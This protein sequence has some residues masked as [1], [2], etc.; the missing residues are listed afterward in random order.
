MLGIKKT[1]AAGQKYLCVAGIQIPYQTE[2]NGFSRRFRIG[3]IEMPY[4]I[5]PVFGI[6][7]PWEGGIK[8]IQYSPPQRQKSAHYHSRELWEDPQKLQQRLEEIYEQRL[9]RRP[10]LNQPRTFTEKLNWLKLHDRR[11]LIAECCDKYSV[12]SYIARS[13]GG[14]W[15]IPTI[16][17]WTAAGDIDFASLPNSFVLKVNWSSGYNV[18]VKDKRLLSR[19]T[20]KRILAQINYWMQPM[21]NSYYD[22]FNWGYK[23][24]RPI[25]YAEEYLDASCTTQEFKI[26]CFHG[27][28]RFVLIEQNN[29]PEAG[30]RVC[31]DLDGKPLPFRFGQQPVTDRYQLP[32]DYARMLESAEILSG[33][34]PFV[35][36]DFLGTEQRR[37]VGEMTFYSGGGFSVISP[38]GW[39]QKL[40]DLLHISRE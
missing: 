22:S 25:A 20:E 27:K 24:S 26:F 1:Q 13:L 4:H 17:A 21:C 34:F 5:S 30:S 31:V 40:G 11:P 29:G 38:D 10:D 33:P 28:P 7:L 6:P 12:K 19:R 32:K 35:R 9:G 39:D 37:M 16:R 15:H 36:I 3:R 18:F 8:S 14:P 2:Q 23:N